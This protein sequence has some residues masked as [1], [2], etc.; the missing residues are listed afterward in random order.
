[1]VLAAADACLSV[2]SFDP[3]LEVMMRTSFTTKVLDY[4]SAGRPI[5]MWGPSFCSPIRLLN[6]R[7]AGLTI[8]TPCPA[9]VL[10]C[11]ER[12]DTEPDL[13]DELSKAA[14]ALADGELSHASIHATF[15]GEIRRL[16]EPAAS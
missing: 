14:L 3:D 13:S 16:V 12:L 4:C 8:T 1:M 9:D 7:R 5:L 15:V 10:A 2:M 11:L 6:R